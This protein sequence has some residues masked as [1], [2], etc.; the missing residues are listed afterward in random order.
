MS[1]PRLEQAPFEQK[2]NFKAVYHGTATVK[3]QTLP[4]EFGRPGKD[5]NFSVFSL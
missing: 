5:L 3:E 1:K 4:A 2:T